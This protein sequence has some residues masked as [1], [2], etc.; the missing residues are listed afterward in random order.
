MLLRTSTPR[1]FADRPGSATRARAQAIP[2]GPRSRL[3]GAPC[4]CS[5]RHSRV[6]IDAV[7]DTFEGQQMV[8]VTARP[9]TADKCNTHYTQ[10]LLAP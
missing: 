1:C 7:V 4:P 8:V 2:L 3:C 10:S 6:G 9:E 5:R